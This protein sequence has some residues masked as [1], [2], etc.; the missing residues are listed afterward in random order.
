MIVVMIPFDRG[1]L[2]R[3]V[4]PFDLAVGPG[5]I[6]LRQP[7][8]DPV[9]VADHVKTHG[10]RIECVPVSRLFGELDA[11]IG[12]DRVD[13]IRQGFE[14]VLKELPRSL[15]IGLFDKLGDSVVA[16]PINADEEIELALDSLDLGDI[17]VEE[18]DWVGLELLTFWLVTIHVWQTRYTMSL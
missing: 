4:H 7:M 5:V 1:V 8:L 10:S 18:A 12:Q 9:Y 6:G 17:Y 13:V 3:A 14:Q 15:A 16:G 11:I 2:D